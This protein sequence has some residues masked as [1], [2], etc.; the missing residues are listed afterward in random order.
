MTDGPNNLTEL[1]QALV[2]ARSSLAGEFSGDFD[3]SAEELRELRLHLEAT[4]GVTL[5][6]A[7]LERFVNEL[8]S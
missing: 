4:F 2:D 1:C 8:R 5:E 6:M 3:A 7:P